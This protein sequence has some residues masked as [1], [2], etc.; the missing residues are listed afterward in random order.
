MKPCSIMFFCLITTAL[1]LSSLNIAHASSSSSSITSTLLA[2]KRTMRKMGSEKPEVRQEDN[3]IK[4]VKT[5]W[6]QAD[7]GSA[8]GEDVDEDGDELLYH[9]DYHGVS[10]HPYPSPKHPRP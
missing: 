3:D 5:Q 2:G 10:T 4:V 6:Q 8:V 9:I 1:Y 7:K